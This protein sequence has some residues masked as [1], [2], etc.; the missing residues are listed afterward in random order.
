[1]PIRNAAISA[2]EGIA[3]VSCPVAPTPALDRFNGNIVALCQDGWQCAMSAA[4]AQIVTIS[5]AVAPITE[6]CRARRIGIAWMIRVTVAGNAYRLAPL[7]N[8]PAAIGEDRQ[9]L[10][11]IALCSCGYRGHS[12]APFPS[13]KTTSSLPGLVLLEERERARIALKNAL[14]MSSICSNRVLTSGFSLPHGR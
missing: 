3:V 14:S 11:P 5:L 10:P 9:P 13:C 4:G 2:F 8:S 7:G 12:A 1:M 6:P